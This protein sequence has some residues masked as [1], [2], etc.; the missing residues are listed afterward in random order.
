MSTGRYI[1]EDPGTGRR[2]WV[3]PIAARN[4][5]ITDREFTNGG[6]DGESV[7]NKSQSLG[8]SVHEE[9]SII[10]KEN[11]FTHITTL[12]PGYSP[13]GYIEYLCRSGKRV[14]E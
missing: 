13:N 6:Y 7:K 3:E 11:G 8:G 5:K 9:D 1:I 10:T 14:G 2:F 12:P 4:E